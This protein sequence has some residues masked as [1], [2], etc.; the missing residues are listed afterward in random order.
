M[1]FST[2]VALVCL[3]TIVVLTRSASLQQGNDVD[4]TVSNDY[5]IHGID[6]V[7]LCVPR[8]YVISRDSYITI[9]YISLRT[10]IIIFHNY[11]K[12]NKNYLEILTI[13]KTFYVIVIYMLYIYIYNKIIY[14]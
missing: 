5:V 3:S 1:S 7:T 14:I 6:D 11:Y 10:L 12:I 4:V 9:R 2:L 8:S 13:L